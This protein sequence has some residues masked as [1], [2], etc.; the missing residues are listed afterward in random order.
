MV[1]IGIVGAGKICQGPHMGA[2]DKIDN[3]EIVAI[4]D[5]DE[6]KLNNLKNR[7]PNAHYYTDYKEMI[8]NEELDA[9]DICTPN[10]YHSIVAIYALDKG[11]NVICE[12][13]DAINA[14]E[15]EKMKAAAEKSGKTL[16]VIRNNRY[17]PSTKYL[18][19]YIADGKMGEIYAG[20]C[21]WIRRRGIPGWGGWFTD[22][23]QSGGGPLIDLG[24]HII[25]LAMYLMG[26]PKPVTVS[27]STYLKFPHTSYSKIDVEDLAMGFIRFDNGACLQIEFSWASNIECDQMFVELRGEKSGSRMSGIDKKFEIFTEEYGSN[28][29]IKP[30]VDDYGVPHHELNIRHFI[31]VIEGKC[32]PDFTPVQGVNMVKIL[33]AIYK[34]AECGHEIA[35]D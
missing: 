24:V 29:T 12:K 10:N 15:A 9:V 16:M 21:G 26:N 5:I 35:L 32:E 30:S 20:R 2:Y 19:K 7:Y 22:K 11:L 34:S 17:R 8:E 6:N 27:G 14:S 4:C 25:D 3:A 28:V 18:K 13:P 23:E 31:D 33:E 1:R